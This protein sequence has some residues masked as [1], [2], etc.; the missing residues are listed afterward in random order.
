LEQV[1]RL[2][3]LFGVSV[4]IS[5]EKRNEIINSWPDYGREDVIGET[6]DEILMPLMKPLDRKLEQYLLKQGYGS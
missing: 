1:Q 4:P 5:I 2:A 6:I 3:A